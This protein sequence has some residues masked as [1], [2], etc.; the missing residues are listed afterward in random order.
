MSDQFIQ[1]GGLRVAY[2]FDGPEKAPV[3]MLS[4]S[5]MSN[6]SM[7]EP[8]MVALTQHFRVL[9]ADTRGHGR[10]E[11]TPGPYSI[12]ML[13]RDAL[14]LMDAL[15]LERVHFVG[16]SKGGM[17]G[18]YLGARHADR[19]ASLALCDT[20]S[21]MPTHAMWDARL[22][23]AREAGIAGLL[24]GTI[25][26][27]FTAPFIERAPQVIDRVRAMILTT[28]VEGYIACASAVRNMSQTSL[29]KDISVPTTVIVGESDPACTVEQ[30]RVLHQHIPGA[31]LTILPDSSHLS[32][33]EQPELFNRA[34]LGFLVKD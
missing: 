12:A 18:Q 20:A 13:A 19:I 32:N 21:E 17:I 30:A 6:F 4:N 11:V 7:W 23:T 14:A 3:V 33:I 34:L 28:P 31:S 16:L 29:L 27:W 25:K 10:T 2:R 24:D 9:R 22:Q 5:L 26:R 15:K 1:A 8:Q